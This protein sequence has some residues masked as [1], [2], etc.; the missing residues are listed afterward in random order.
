M[1]LFILSE[2]LVVVLGR[3][4]A[5]LLVLYLFIFALF[6]LVAA[7]LLLFGNAYVRDKIELLRNLRLFAQGIDTAINAPSSEVLPA[8][9]E[10]DNRLGQVVQAIHT[11]QSVQVVQRVK[12]AQR[13]ANAIEKTVDQDTDRIA[14]AVIE[15]RARS[16]M[17]QGMLKAFFLPG[18]TKQKP[19]AALL[20][21]ATPE[22]LTAQSSGVAA[23]VTGPLDSIDDRHLQPVDADQPEPLASEGAERANDAPGR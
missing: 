14:S 20:P 22:S 15:F 17:V 9:V 4:A 13:Q 18:L 5:L 7:L 2:E 11:V 16:V 21:R 19:R 6:F 1:L 12:D 8:V 23:A 10:P 3:I